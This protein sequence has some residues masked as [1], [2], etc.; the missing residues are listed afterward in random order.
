LKWDYQRKAK[1]ES[2]SDEDKAKLN[3]VLEVAE[4]LTTKLNNIVKLD[5]E[6]R[7]KAQVYKPAL[8]SESRIWTDEAGNRYQFDMNKAEYSENDGLVLTMHQIFDDDMDASVKDAF[9]R[10][11]KTIE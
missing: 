7:A 9:T 2:V 4:G 1:D 8:E 6:A 3:K 11:D 5:V 10:L